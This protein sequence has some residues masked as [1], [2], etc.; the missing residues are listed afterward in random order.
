MHTL[1]L[2]QVEDMLANRVLDIAMGP[3]RIRRFIPQGL[4]KMR[5]QDS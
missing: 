2:Q 3:N 1:D 4:V 5:Q